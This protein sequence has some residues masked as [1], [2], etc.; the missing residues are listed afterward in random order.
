MGT[1]CIAL[2]VRLELEKMEFVVGLEIVA[3]GLY[4]A[5]SSSWLFYRF[6]L[7]VFPRRTDPSTASYSCSLNSNTR[8]SS[9]TTTTSF[10]LLLLL[11]VCCGVSFWHLLLFFLLDTSSTTDFTTPTTTGCSSLCSSSCSSSSSLQISTR[12]TR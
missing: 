2:F 8:P 5:G 12:P 1:A 11:F 9:S 3:A 7:F 6:F 10:L 4:P